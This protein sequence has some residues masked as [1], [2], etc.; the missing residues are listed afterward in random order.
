MN[1][2]GTSH[3]MSRWSSEKFEEDLASLSEMFPACDVSVLKNYLEMFWDDPNYLSA[4]VNMLLE[5]DISP[6][7]NQ[8]QNSIQEQNG[9]SESR[10]CLK[11]KADSDEE[12]MQNKNARE[13]EAISPVKL[14]RTDANRN[15]GDSFRSDFINKMESKLQETSNSGASEETSTGRQESPHKE[16]KHGLNTSKKTAPSNP[17]SQLTGGTSPLSTDDSEIAFVK[18]V[19]SP[20]KRSFYRTGQPNSEARSHSKRVGICIRYRGGALHPSM[21]K[22]KKLQIVEIDDGPN[23]DI[24]NQSAPKKAHSPN[25]PSA[26]SECSIAASSA[27]CPTVTAIS[28]A[29]DDGLPEMCTNTQSVSKENISGNKDDAIHRNETNHDHL[30]VVATLDDLEILRKVFPDAEPDY[31]SSLLEKY[32]DQHNRVALVGKELG[33]NPNPQRVKNKLIPSASWF[34]QSEEDKLIPFTDSEC[35]ALEKEFSGYDPLHSDV[36]HIRLPGSTKSYIVNFASM[37]MTNE[38]GLRIT[39]VRITGDTEENKQM[40]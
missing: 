6:G 4:I 39:I 36:V 38:V 18:S 19:A 17:N 14:K 32:A 21:N 35:N 5:A 29:D 31:I 8:V 2:A 22:P 25:S 24:S 20:P 26:A 10:L 34:W 12:H 28:V 30:P 13:R 3:D 23:D 7:I 33:T 16:F 1:N 27:S 37:T 9:N 40:R 11:R 15:E